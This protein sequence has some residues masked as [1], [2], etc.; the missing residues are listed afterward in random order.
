[1]W[2]PLLV[3]GYNEEAYVLYTA[4]NKIQLLCKQSLE[5]KHTHIYIYKLTQQHT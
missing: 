5:N 1:M 4:S 2:E 3:V